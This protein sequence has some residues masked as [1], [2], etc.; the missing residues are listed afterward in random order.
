MVLLS[1]TTPFAALF[2]KDADYAYIKVFLCLAY[3]SKLSI[4]RSKFDPRVRPC[5]IMGFPIGMKGYKLYGITKR[6]IFVSKDIL[7]FEEL[8]PFC[9]TKEDTNFVTYDFLEQF[10]TH[11]PLFN[12]SEKTNDLS[13][14]VEHSTYNTIHEANP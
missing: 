4:N 2:G 7:F 10:V 12:I 1:N 6:K 8:F 14:V 13:H 9:S 5:V 11:C 3:A